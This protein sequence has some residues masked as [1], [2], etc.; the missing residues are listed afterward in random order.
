MASGVLSEAAVNMVDLD[1]FGP[2]KKKIRNQVQKANPWK[3]SKPWFSMDTMDS[4]VG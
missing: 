2:L 4:M 3:M 1:L